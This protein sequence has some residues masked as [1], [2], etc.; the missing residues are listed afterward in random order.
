LNRRRL[1][2]RLASGALQN[3]RFDDATDLLVG[4]GIQLVRVSGSHHIYSHPDVAELLSLQNAGGEAKPYQLR[5]LMR[6]VERYNLG[7][8]SE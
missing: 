3:V 2:R 8:E 6:L 1:L 7:L 5:Q 4:L